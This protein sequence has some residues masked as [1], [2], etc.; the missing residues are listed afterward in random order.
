LEVL[1]RKAISHSLEGFSFSRDTW[2]LDEAALYRDDSPLVQDDGSDAVNHFEPGDFVDSG[3]S[4]HPEEDFFMGD[5]A[6]GDD[7]GGDDPVAGGYGDENDS[8]DAQADLRTIGA[9]G[10]HPMLLDP[11][12]APNERA[13]IMA[14]TDAE[15][16][17]GMMD[18]FDQSVLRNWAGPEHWKLRK[19]VR[20]R[21]CFFPISAP[22]CLK[23]LCCAAETTEAAATSKPKRERKEAFKIDFLSPAEKDPKET[24]KELFA[25]VTRGAGVTLPKH[26][27]G[28]GSRRK[29]GKAREKQND[30]TLP[31]DMHFSS[32]QLVTLFLKPKFSVSLPF[33]L[34]SGG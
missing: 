26:S 20:R 28:K 12:R 11:R 1:E 21:S 33:V 22:S 4:A 15:G 30:H 29:K 7:F 5:Q 31:D 16:E 27:S 14:M 9:D 32:R 34:L 25:P 10:G 13:L 19:T 8:P 17:G 3:Q 2:A 23:E 18:Y 6:V 24:V